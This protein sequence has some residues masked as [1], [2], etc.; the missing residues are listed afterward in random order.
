MCDNTTC[1]V[2]HRVNMNDVDHE[3]EFIGKITY[4][5]D[6]VVFTGDNSFEM[7]TTMLGLP[8][9]RHMTLLVKVDDKPVGDYLASGLTERV[10]D[11]FFH[12]SVSEAEDGHDMVVMGVESGLLTA[13]AKVTSPIQVIMRYLDEA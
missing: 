4:L 10:Y 1:A 13:D 2:H 12:S 7:Y 6:W 5:G 8:E 9:F 11:G 3:A